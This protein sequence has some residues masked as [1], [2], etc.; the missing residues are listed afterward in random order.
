MDGGFDVVDASRHPVRLEQDEDNS[1][2]F[3]FAAG[4]ARRHVG[5]VRGR[6]RGFRGDSSLPGGESGVLGNPFYANLLGRWL[7]NESHPLRQRAKDFI[8]DAVDVR[9]F[10]PPPGG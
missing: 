2:R 9:L 10:A 5:E 1:N 3:M 7:T 6:R 8:D 4:P